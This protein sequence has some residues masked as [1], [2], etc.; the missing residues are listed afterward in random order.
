MNHGIGNVKGK[1]GGAIPT[2]T[3]ELSQMLS[4]NEVQ[5]TN[6]QFEI[7]A[8]NSFI[9]VALP[10]G[11]VWGFN[12]VQDDYGNYH[13]AMCVGSSTEISY[14]TGDINSTTK[15]ITISMGDFSGGGGSG[16]GGSGSQLYQYNLSYRN[17]DSQ[18][19][20]NINFILSDDLTDIASFKTWLT[21]NNYTSTSNLFYIN[22]GHYKGNPAYAV[23]LD[24]NTI[25]IG[26]CTPGG[27]SITYANF[28]G[29][30]I[31]KR[32]L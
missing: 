17:V 5:L 19:L 7:I 18:I 21:N 11:Q 30:T 24:N 10:T 3:I 28:D 16:S 14:T 23:Y 9:S 29:S 31:I 22:G 2:I 13:L 6:E 25:K 32:A 1:G 27:Y 12:R 4:A 15:I 20:T 26:Y 8:N